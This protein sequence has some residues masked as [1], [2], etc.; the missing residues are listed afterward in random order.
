MLKSMKSNN[1]H[2]AQSKIG[3]QRRERPWVPQQFSRAHTF[4]FCQYFLAPISSEFSSL[5]F[6]NYPDTFTI[7]Y[8]FLNIEVLLT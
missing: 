1:F 6:S 4:S 8:S 3:V 7:P 2:I 5:D